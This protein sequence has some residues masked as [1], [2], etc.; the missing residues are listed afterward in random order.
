[1]GKVPLIFVRLEI[2]SG[3]GRE[4]TT[5]MNSKEGSLKDNRPNKMTGLKTI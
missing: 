1:M 2:G 5:C 4:E 3:F